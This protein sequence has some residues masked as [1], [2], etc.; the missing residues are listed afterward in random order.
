[1][2]VTP[3]DSTNRTDILC[4][5]VWTDMSIF[6]FKLPSLEKIF[7]H[8]LPG[9]II[10]R[11]ILTSVFGDAHYLFIAMGDGKL[12]HFLLNKVNGKYKN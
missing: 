10:P 3:R 4:V 2:D 5:G 1:M 7:Y 11:S 12:Y 6:I 9:N 8:K